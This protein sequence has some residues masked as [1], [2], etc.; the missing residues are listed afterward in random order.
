MHHGE[1][2]SFGSARVCSP[3]IFETCFSCDKD[4]SIWIA[5]IDYY[6]SFYMIVVGTLVGGCRCIT[7]WCDLDFT[8]DLVVLTMSHTLCSQCKHCLD[9]FM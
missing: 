9:L 7:S 2:F 8:F 1:T 4:T 5:A 6:M 3:A